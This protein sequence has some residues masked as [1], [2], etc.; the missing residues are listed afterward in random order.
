MDSTDSIITQFLTEIDGLE[1]LKGV[2]LIAATNR[3]DLVDTAFIRNGRFDRH[4]YVPL[5]DEK[6][7]KKI[8][9]IY[10][11]KMPLENNIDINQLVEKTKNFVGADIENLCRETSMEVLRNNK[12]KIKTVSQK[13][14]FKTLD[15]FKQSIKQEEI[16]AFEQLAKKTKNLQTDKLT[17][18]S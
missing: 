18:F 12:K 14:F 11:K 1:G 16:N 7:R 4:I 8:F 5:P 2:I 10:T 3:P 9:E 13:D 15:S 17:Y 6:S